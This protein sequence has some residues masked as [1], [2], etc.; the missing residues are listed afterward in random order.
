MK[1]RMLPVLADF[2]NQEI[3]SVRSEIDNSDAQAKRN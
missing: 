1:L 3:E 2:G